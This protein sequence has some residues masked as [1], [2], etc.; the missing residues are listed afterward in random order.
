[1]TQY[2]LLLHLDVL[3]E[4]RTLERAAATQPA[5]GLCDRASSD[6]VPIRQPLPPDLRQALAAAADIALAGG[7]LGARPSPCQ[8]VPRQH[9][10]RP[11]RAL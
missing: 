7:A 9:N 1:V 5:G 2:R 4:L 11:G 10:N 8:P 6:I 3:K